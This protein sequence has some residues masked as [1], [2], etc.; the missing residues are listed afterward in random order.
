MYIPMLL[1]YIVTIIVCLRCS[2]ANLISAVNSALMIN[3]LHVFGETTSGKFRF[4]SKKVV[5]IELCR[6]CFES[7]LCLFHIDVY[8]LF[9]CYLTDLGMCNGW[10]RDSQILLS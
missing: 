3:V 5:N 10:C 8:L 6:A 7:L 2:L 4:S 1:L 9:N